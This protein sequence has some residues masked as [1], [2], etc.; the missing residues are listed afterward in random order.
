MRC[1]QD[2]YYS[3]KHAMKRENSKFSCHSLALH[4]SNKRQ[5]IETWGNLRFYSKTI[6]LNEPK[7]DV[8]T[9]KIYCLSKTSEQ[10]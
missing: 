4:S 3:G 8:T 9:A 2:E 1:C 7:N 5:E 6:Q 10:T